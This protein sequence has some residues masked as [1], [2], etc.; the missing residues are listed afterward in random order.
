MRDG[1]PRRA[2][3]RPAAG[4]EPA[5]HRPA[6]QDAVAFEQPFKEFRERWIDHREREYLRRLLDRHRRNAP[7][8]AEPAGLDRTYVYRLI[9]KHGL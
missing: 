5:V 1:R 4:K 3:V 6:R 2:A 7:A 9:P 8:A